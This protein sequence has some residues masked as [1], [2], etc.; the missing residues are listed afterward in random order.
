MADESDYL[1]MQR[2]FYEDC[3]SH[4]SLDHPNPVV[5][6]YEAHNAWADYDTYLFKGFETRGLVAL[7][8]GAGPGR[9]IIRFWDRFWRIDGVDI[10]KRN[11]QKARINL[12]NAGIRDSRLYVCDGKSIPVEDAVYDVVFSVI[13]MQH[14]CCHSIRY[15]ILQDIYRVLKPGGRLC[16]Q[17]GYG[18]RIKSDPAKN[19]NTPY[20]WIP[21]HKFKTVAYF[22]N[23]THAK[24]TNGLHDV[25]IQNPAEPEADLLEIG[26][27]DFGFDLRPTGPGDTHNQWI[28][29][30]AMKP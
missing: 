3:A 23:A 17:M 26:F 19:K 30:Q 25:T 6:S 8:Y 14:I 21:A 13:C 16:F 27:K 24:E 11:I 4:W 29:M 18:G 22:D 1:A 9:N 2:R 15:K 7:E 12:E 5:G 20:R 28:F 10:A